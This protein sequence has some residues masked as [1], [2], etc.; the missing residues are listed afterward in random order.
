MS[1]SEMNL[2]ERNALSAAIEMEKRGYDFFKR[3]AAEAKDSLAKEVFDFLAAEELNHI[4]AIEKFNKEY[5]AGG[6]SDAD[7]AIEELKAGKPKTA[8]ARLF[9]GLKDKTPVKGTELEVY[10]FA[11]DF[12]KKGEAFYRK[13]EESAADP[14]SKKLY[15]FLVGEE[16]NHFKIVE[17]CLNYFENPEEFFHQRERWHLEG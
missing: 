17:A 6:S 12:E 1:M 14:N 3:S 15:G 11:M 2:P 10:R 5:L 4:R 9:E 16:R 7:A 13:A 8:I